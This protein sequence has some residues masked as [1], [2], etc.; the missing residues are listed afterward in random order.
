MKKKI[1]KLYDECGSAKVEAP[2]H[3]PKAV[4][5]LLEKQASQHYIKKVKKKQKTDPLDHRHTNLLSIISNTMESITAIDI[6]NI[7]F[8]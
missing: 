1:V 4:F 2:Y 6:K 8:L 3:L 5:H 7:V